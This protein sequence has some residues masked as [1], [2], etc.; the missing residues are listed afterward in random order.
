MIYLLKAK[1]RVPAG[2]PAVLVIYADTPQ[3]ANNQIRGLGLPAVEWEMQPLTVAP[4]QVF[5]I[6]Y[7]QAAGEVLPSN[8]PTGGRAPETPVVHRNGI[9][10]NYD[11]GD[12]F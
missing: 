8:L 4:G 7:S 10:G 6:L 12:E 11:P 5:Q 9:I 1:Q 2:K 3:T